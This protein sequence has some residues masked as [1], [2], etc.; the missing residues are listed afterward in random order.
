LRL[1]KKKYGTGIG[2][3]NGK[4]LTDNVMS[5]VPEKKKKV[6]QG[7]VNTGNFHP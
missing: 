2:T 6:P 5:P 1:R 3:D 4:D 7:T